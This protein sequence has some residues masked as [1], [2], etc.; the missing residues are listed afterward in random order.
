MEFQQT[1]RRQVTCAGIGLHAG[2]KVSLTLK[3]APAGTGVVFRRTDLG[4][5]I[6]ARVEHVTGI[7]Y[8]TVNGYI[9]SLYSKLHVRSRTEAVVKYLEH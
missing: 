7:T 9:K 2:T 1:L 6:P 8:A 5:D 3:P 4:V